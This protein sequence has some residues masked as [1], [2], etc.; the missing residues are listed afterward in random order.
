[1]AAEADPIPTVVSVAPAAGPGPVRVW[2]RSIGA[3]LGLPAGASVALHVMIA[4][5]AGLLIWDIAW[6]SPRP[7]PEV[8]IAFDDP[9]QGS[10]PAGDPAPTPAPAPERPLAPPP[11]PA[12][13]AAPVL[14]GLSPVASGQDHPLSMT[15][16][17]AR[18][19][20]ALEPR[21]AG[22]PPGP[23]VEFA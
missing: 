13:T 18:A 4:V 12:P 22:A 10:T 15:S 21:T 9:G 20:P 17:P 19:T 6:H 14:T 8:V 1:M 3:R 2:P 7:G 11:T 5:G 23:A 16:E